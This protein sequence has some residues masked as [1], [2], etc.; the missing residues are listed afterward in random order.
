MPLASSIF[1]RRSRTSSFRKFSPAFSSSTSP[2]HPP[3][4]Q[5][6]LRAYP[7]INAT[8][9]FPTPSLPAV[10]SSESQAPIPCLSSAENRSLSAPDEPC[11]DPKSR[12]TAFPPATSPRA[13]S[14]LISFFDGGPSVEFCYPFSLRAVPNCSFCAALLFARASSADNLMVESTFFFEL[15]INNVYAKIYVRI[16]QQT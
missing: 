7:G 11:H 15:R 8:S 10:P 1:T 3:G 14:F 13:E 9:I 6:S 5:V 2:G 12:V 4:P 16:K